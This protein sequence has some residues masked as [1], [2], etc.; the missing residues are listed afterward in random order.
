MQPT[1]RLLSNNRWHFQHGPIDLILEAFGDQNSIDGAFENAWIRFSSVLSELV[2]ELPNLRKPVSHPSRI[3]KLSCKIPRGEVAW[4]MWKAC[5]DLITCS[6]GEF[7]TP[8]ASVAGAVSDTIIDSFKVAGVDKAWVN[9]GGDIALHLTNEHSVEIGI[10]GESN[11]LSKKMLINYYSTKLTERLDT[12]QIVENS[13]VTGKFKVDY[14]MP[15]RGVATS[16][17]GGRSFT[18]G[19][20]DSVTVLAQNS[21]LADAAATLIANAV[22]LDLAGIVRKPANSLKDDSDLGDILVTVEVPKLEDEVINIA[23]NAG[24]AKA[25]NLSQALIRSTGHQIYYALIYLQGKVGIYE[26]QKDD[27]SRVNHQGDFDKEV[28]PTA[29]LNTVWV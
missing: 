14:S 17:R 13:H 9:N 24:V 22:N 8:M 28:L 10:V 27:H 29:N 4:M 7:L 2:Q 19:I 21:A 16:G 11:N 3:D 6:P 25:V 23:I 15:V 26:F 18:L 20:A 12:Q 5:S 1:R